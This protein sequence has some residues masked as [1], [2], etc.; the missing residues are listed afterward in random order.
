MHGAMLFPTSA[1]A[2][3]QN[4][5]RIAFASTPDTAMFR[6]TGAFTVTRHRHPAWK[7]VLPLDGEVVVASDRGHPTVT[8]AGVIVPPQLTHTCATTS[9]FVALFVD[10]W[11]L[12]R[13]TGLTPLTA[14][15]VRR[16][17][18]ALDPDDVHGPDLSA[19]HAALIT[20]VGAGATLESRVTYAVQAATTGAQAIGS[21]ATEVGLSSPRL[22]ALVHTSVGIPLA[23][24]RLWARLG[25]ALA[26]LPGQSTAEA[27][28]T[29]GFADQPHLARTARSL[30][31][32]TINSLRKAN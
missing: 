30:V 15:Q 3:E 27:A 20:L 29:A 8:A 25:A 16:M 17:L 11:L 2:L 24:L 19:A 9:D 10:P 12:R 14:A 7:V 23:R 26:A 22:R 1:W 31:G 4:D 21:I 28:A 32:R 18:A 13:H 6:Q 5:R